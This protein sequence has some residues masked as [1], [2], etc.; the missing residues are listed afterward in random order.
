MQA[1]AA[2]E[3]S[4]AGA[5]PQQPA[6]SL[7][8]LEEP[9]SALVPASMQRPFCKWNRIYCLLFFLPY[10]ILYDTA[11]GFISISA[12]AAVVSPVHGIRNCIQNVT[13]CITYLFYVHAA[14]CSFY[15]SL[16]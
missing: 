16:L 3:Y 12:Q 10:H 13:A 5:L 9:G 1:E 8:S 4:P 11:D 6:D 14:T 2:P 15:V 7:S